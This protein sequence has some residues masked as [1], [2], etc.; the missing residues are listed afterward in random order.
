LQKSLA[1][2]SLSYATGD[3]IPEAR[4]NAARYVVP[5]TSLTDFA[6]KAS[7]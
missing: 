3:A 2:L 5:L 6:R 1:A 7:A 4:D